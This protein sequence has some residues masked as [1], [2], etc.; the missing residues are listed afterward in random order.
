MANV[1]A[2]VE[3]KDSVLRSV[4][5]QVVTA[6]ADVARGLGGEAHAL[7][8][9][10]PGLAAAVGAL[11]Q[12]GAARIHVG[13]HE[14][15]AGY[16]PDP[17]AAAVAGFAHEGSYAAMLFA[18]S[19]QG[20]DLAPR[21]AALLDV[22]L[23]ND[24]VALD[25]AGGTL[26]VV[27]P[28]YAGKAF[29]RVR[30]QASPF[31]VSI[32]PNVFQPGTRTAA[33][34]VASFTP[35]V[36]P[37]R[38]RL[39]EFRAATGGSMDVGEASIV[40]AGGRGMRDPAQWSVLEEL[41][42]AIGEGAALG[43]SRAVVDAGWRPHGEQVGQTGKTV[44]PKL[45]FAVGISGAIQHLAGMRTSGTIVAINKDPEAPIFK[46]ADYGIVGD[47]FEVVPRLAEEI[48]ALREG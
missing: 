8:L 11:G 18:G 7:A 48:R 3:Q 14:A 1:L 12:S 39:R 17:Y 43:T 29:A 37:A 36:G 26:A 2:V 45:Y 46:V 47:L 19:L 6:A 38:T 23:A 41:R 24:A 42:D 44:S 35:E 4:S 13:E 16:L 32:R 27:R 25:T 34:A 22:P 5:A 30:S 31:L 15:L 40:V 9:G 10:A 33:G 20:R 28:V 21:V